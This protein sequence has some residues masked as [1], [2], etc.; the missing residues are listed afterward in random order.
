MSRGWGDWKP[1]NPKFNIII[2]LLLSYLFDLSFL[3]FFFLFLLVFKFLDIEII[4]RRMIKP[5]HD[6]QFQFCKKRFLFLP[7]HPD[8][9]RL[10][11]AILVLFFFLLFFGHAL[12]HY[13]GLSTPEI[14]DFSLQRERA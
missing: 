3:F 4:A 10:T 2:L 14:A 9:Q 5:S 11:L 6:D 13:E 1:K 8:A 12:F 7:I